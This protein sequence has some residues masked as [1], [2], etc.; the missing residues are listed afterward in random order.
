MIIKLALYV[1]QG[2]QTES[3]QKKL[4]Q[5]STEECD[6]QPLPSCLLFFPFFIHLTYIVPICIGLKPA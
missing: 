4:I 3:Y 1:L 6:D 5:K 2:R